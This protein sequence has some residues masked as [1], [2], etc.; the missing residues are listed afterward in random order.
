M[1]EQTL[2]ALV[3]LVVL[4]GGMLVIGVTAVFEHT[5]SGREVLDRAVR[6]VRGW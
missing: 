3:A 2:N 1:D 6:K 5:D 4:A